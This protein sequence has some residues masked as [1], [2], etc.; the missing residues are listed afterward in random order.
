MRVRDAVKRRVGW[1]A[2]LAVA[3]AV[4]LCVWPTPYMVWSVKETTLFGTTTHVTRVNRFT[5]TQEEATSKGWRTRDQIRAETERADAAARAR[6]IQDLT[7]VRVDDVRDKFG[8]LAILNPTEWELS[9]G[10][11]VVEYF[12][13]GNRRFELIGGQ[14]VDKGNEE[15]LALVELTFDTLHRRGYTDVATVGVPSEPTPPEE[16]TDPN[17]PTEFVQRVTIR[18]SDACS[19]RGKHVTLEPPFTLRH[20]MTWTNGAREPK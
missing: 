9:N 18:C 20:S 19:E 12:R 17:A 10:T 3:I 8:M 5:G 16:V 14:V 7:A 1:L 2:G 4:A 6:A 11:V 15:F 13:K